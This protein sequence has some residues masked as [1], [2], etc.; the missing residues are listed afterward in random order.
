MRISE[1]IE[2]LKLAIDRLHKG[3]KNAWGQII[4]LAQEQIN[5][6]SKGREEGGSYLFGLCDMYDSQPSLRK[7]SALKTVCTAIEG[8]KKQL[9][10]IIEAAESGIDSDVLGV[11]IKDLEILRDQ[12]ASRIGTLKISREFEKGMKGS[13]N[14]LNRI[15][16]TEL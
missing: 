3:S 13:T 4:K 16:K 12:L 11:S 8:L 2:E 6:L 9:R 14:I 7:I 15:E 1:C 5:V 10:L